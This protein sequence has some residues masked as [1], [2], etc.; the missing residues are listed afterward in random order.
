MAPTGRHHTR[1]PLAFVAWIF[2]PIRAYMNCE[3]SQINKRKS[4]L[5]DAGE[6]IKWAKSW[7]LKLELMSFGEVFYRPP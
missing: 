1:R 3:R 4:S 2:F 5:A 6:R 7:L